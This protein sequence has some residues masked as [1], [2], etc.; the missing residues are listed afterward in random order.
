MARRVGAIGLISWQD[1]RN[2]RP[3]VGASLWT[4]VR[5]ICAMAGFAT[6]M[7]P[8]FGLLRWS[9]PIAAVAAGLLLLAACAHIVAVARSAIAWVV[10]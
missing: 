3:R 2:R 9:G 1:S 8:A 10:G 4:A 7:V 5:L 6:L